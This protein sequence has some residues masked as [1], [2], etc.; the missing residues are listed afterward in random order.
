M[1]YVWLTWQYLTR[2]LPGALAALA[3]YA[4][5]YPGRRRRLGAAGLVSSRLRECLLALFWMFGGGMAALFYLAWKMYQMP[6]PVEDET[7]LPEESPSD[8]EKDGGADDGEPG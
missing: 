6:V 3:L 1:R 4:C 8:G 5:L 2:M 7:A